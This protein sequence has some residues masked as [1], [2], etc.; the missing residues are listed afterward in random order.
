MSLQPK[1]PAFD[2][3]GQLLFLDRLDTL[4]A[5]LSVFPARMRR[6]GVGSARSWARDVDGGL[7]GVGVN[8]EGLEAAVRAATGSMRDAVAARAA[9][10][11]ASAQPGWAA[12]ELAALGAGPEVRAAL[13]EHPAALS[14]PRTLA[15]VRGA[16]FAGAGGEGNTALLADPAV[17]PVLRRLMR[18]K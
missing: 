8:L 16:L 5:R 7:S 14:D 10:G 15:A 4:A 1:F 6:C 2:P 17:G 18:R 13:V 11:P 9:A 3:A 12:A